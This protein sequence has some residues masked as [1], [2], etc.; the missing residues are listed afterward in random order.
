MPCRYTLA[1]R[2]SILGFYG[3]KQMLFEQKC[4]NVCATFN[5]KY[6]ISEQ[7]REHWGE[8]KNE[9]SKKDVLKRLCAYFLKNLGWTHKYDNATNHKFLWL[10]YI[11][12]LCL[13]ALSFSRSVVFMGAHDLPTLKRSSQLNLKCSCCFVCEGEIEESPWPSPPCDHA[14]IP[15]NAHSRCQAGF[16]HQWTCCCYTYSP[17]TIH[18][19]PSC[20]TFSSAVLHFSSFLSLYIYSLFCLP[21]LLSQPCIPCCRSIIPAFFHLIFFPPAAPISQHLAHNLGGFP[22]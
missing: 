12:C 5:N 4:R 3:C 15:T 1:A 19:L 11:Q 7:T 20:H 8:E 14:R 21:S 16:T 22:E 13:R 10:D 17:L 2:V 6:H 18:P 9:L